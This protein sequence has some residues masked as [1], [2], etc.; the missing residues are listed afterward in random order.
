MPAAAVAAQPRSAEAL[1]ELIVER[2]FGELASAGV[3]V[4]AAPQLA[5]ALAAARSAAVK[6]LKTDLRGVQNQAAADARKMLR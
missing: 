6:R 5:T 2:Y 1:A 4:A 3:D